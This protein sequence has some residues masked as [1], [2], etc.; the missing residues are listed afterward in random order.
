MA[1]G[2][3]V[4]QFFQM[5]VMRER[6][7]TDSRRLDCGAPEVLRIENGSEHHQ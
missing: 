2:T 3:V 7:R 6:H 4:T 5:G 1:E